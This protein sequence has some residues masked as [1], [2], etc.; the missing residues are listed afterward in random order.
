MTTHISVRLA[1]HDNGWNGSI[2]REP[3]SNTY[4]VG[5]YSYQGDMLIR[6]RDLAWEQPRA[7]QPCCQLDRVPRVRVIFLR[8]EGW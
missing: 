3:K 1:W 7:G 2:C 5:Q 8:E 4:C 6:D